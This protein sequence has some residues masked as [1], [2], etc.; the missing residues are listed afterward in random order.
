MGTTTRVII[1]EYGNELYEYCN[2]NL[3]CREEYRLENNSRRDNKD[4]S[5]VLSAFELYN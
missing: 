1:A 4:V 2:V 5:F 3:P